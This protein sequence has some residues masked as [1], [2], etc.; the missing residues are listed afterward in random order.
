MFTSQCAFCIGDLFPLLFFSL[1]FYRSL[2]RYW[3]HFVKR[4]L[5]R[6]SSKWLFASR[7]ARR[8]HEESIRSRFSFCFLVGRIAT[9]SDEPAGLTYLT[10]L[11]GAV[12]YLVPHVSIIACVLHTL[13]P[14]PS[15]RFLRA[16]FSYPL[17][18]CSFSFSPIYMYILVYGIR[19]IDRPPMTSLHP[20]GV[21]SSRW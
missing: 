8:I 12:P 20:Q 17:S 10:R 13:F 4:Y 16:P 2:F 21:E 14:F 18:Y 1:L 5:R 7:R 3:T 6:G 19:A 11:L 15:L 9:A